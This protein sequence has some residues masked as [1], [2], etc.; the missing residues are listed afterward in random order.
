MIP[1]LRFVVWVTTL[2]ASIGVLEA[3]T[4]PPVQDSDVARYSAR[5]TPKPLQVD[6]KLTEEAWLHAPKSPRFVDLISGKKAVHNTQ[7]AVLWDDQYLYVGYWI[8][9]PFLE[10]TLR[11]RDSPIYTNNDVECFIAGEDGY[12]EFEINAYGTI[13]EGLFFW[14]DAYEKLGL[15]RMP[16]FDRLRKE[17]RGQEFNGVGLT[18]HPRG[19]RW[20]LLG[21]DYPDAKSAVWLDGTLNDNSDRDRGWTVELAFPW[22]GLKGLQL[23]KP[24]S[25]PP[26]PGDVWRMDFSRF[27]QYKAAKPDQDSGGWA[28]SHHGVWDSHVPECFPY[29]TFSAELS[30]PPEGTSSTS[31]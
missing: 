28:W 4:F 2:L 1:S 24:R 16:E 3:Q 21:W 13:Y 19:K 12:Y 5:R 22:Q 17:L 29:V 10:A 6:G 11:D 30:V 7:A 25:L 8:E 9:E 14:Q 23:S 18:N 15:Q 20:A 27:N 26:K 31:R